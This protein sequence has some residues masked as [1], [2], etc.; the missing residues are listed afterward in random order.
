MIALYDTLT[1]SL[2]E[3]SVKD[4]PVNI[5]CCGPTVYRDAA[6]H[7]PDRAVRVNAWVLLYERTDRND[8]V[9]EQMSVCQDEHLTADGYRLLWYH[10]IQKEQRDRA[11]R[12]DSRLAS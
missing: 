5:Y 8:Q 7:T 6:N 3:L 11:T 1:R 9:I 10:S 12:A 2:K 4:N